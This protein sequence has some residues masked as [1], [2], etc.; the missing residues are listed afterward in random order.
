MN[1]Q[2]WAKKNTPKDSLFQVDPSHYYGWRDYSERSSLGNLRE[3]GFTSIAYK[4]DLNTYK[5]GIKLIEKFGIDLS[6]IYHQDIKIDG[7][8]E[9]NKNLSKIVKD[10][11]YSMGK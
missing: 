9:L 10:K 2:L 1:T 7:S 3:W 4:S 11:Y 6:K 8:F 5:K